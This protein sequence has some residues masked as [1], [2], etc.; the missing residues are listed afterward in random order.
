MTTTTT[1]PRERRW[2]AKPHEVRAIL[3]GR[4]TQMRRVVTPQPHHPGLTPGHNCAAPGR[5]GVVFCRHRRDF[6]TCDVSEHRWSP[7]G[8]PGDRL[9]VPE[10]FYCDDVRSFGVG[11]RNKALR[12]EFL[13]EMYYRAD[14]ECCDQIAECVHDG[15]DD[16]GARWRP[17]IH[18]PRWASRLTLEITGVR[19]ERVQAISEADA[20]AEGVTE[21][22]VADLLG[23]SERAANCAYTLGPR[24]LWE[25]GWTAINGADSWTRNEWVWV[26]E[27]RRVARAGAG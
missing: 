12:A 4:Q 10:T 6:E 3:D 1:T 25:L 16:P 5:W 8:A 23:D 11:L 7:F 24:G 9:W 17:S 14:G 2:L 15:P 19:V 13:R 22:A 18:M 27:F 21:R 20:I 26:V